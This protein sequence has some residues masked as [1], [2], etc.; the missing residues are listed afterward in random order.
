MKQRQ[1]AY[2]NA[3]ETARKVIEG[4]RIAMDQIHG[5]SGK[6]I[7]KKGGVLARAG[8]ELALKEAQTGA[9]R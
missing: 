3:M 4:Y 2:L 7:P 1:D 9:S 8:Y 6:S 5:H